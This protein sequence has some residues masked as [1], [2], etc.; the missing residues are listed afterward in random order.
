MIINIMEGLIDLRGTN[1]LER[2]FVL[3]FLK[4][5]AS[6]KYR[7]IFKRAEAEKRKGKQESTEAEPEIDVSF[8]YENLFNPQ[9]VQPDQFN[10]LVENGMRLINEVVTHNMDKEQLDNFLAVKV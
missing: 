1:A 2:K 10:K 3:A 6:I 9:E 7:D 8:L 4:G 5:L